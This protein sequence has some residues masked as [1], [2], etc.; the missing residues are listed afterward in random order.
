MPVPSPDDLKRRAR[1]AWG[2]SLLGQKALAD[3]TGIEARTLDSLLAPKGRTPSVEQAW[4]IAAA[5]EVPTD[6]VI[7]GWAWASRERGMADRLANLEHQ[8]DSLLQRFSTPEDEG[9]TPPD[10]VAPSP[11]I[12]PP[13]GEQ[14]HQLP[15]RQPTE[16]DHPP[17]LETDEAA[18]DRAQGS[19]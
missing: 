19:G 1:A 11:G 18:D 12:P 13:G 9:A 8:V 17:M 7:D 14:P 4:K 16:E 3:E 15:V 5:C 10:A 2:Y 6:F